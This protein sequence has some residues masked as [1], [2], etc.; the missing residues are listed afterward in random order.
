MRLRHRI[1]TR[2]LGDPQAVAAYRTALDDLDDHIEHQLHRHQGGVPETEERE[3]LE[4]RVRETRQLVP[5]WRQ[6]DPPWPHQPRRAA[7]NHHSS[8]PPHRGP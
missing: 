3:L 8:R 2:I 1:R 6:E 4:T 7:P 5:W